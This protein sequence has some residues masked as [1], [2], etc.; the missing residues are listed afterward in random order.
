[1]ATKRRIK[2]RREA[3]TY[4][5]RKKPPPFCLKEIVR[6]IRRNKKFAKFIAEQLCKAHKGDKEAAACVD[7]Y[8]K[9]TNS[10]L[11]ALC[12]PKSLRPALFDKC[13]DH[14]TRYLLIDVA[15]HGVGETRKC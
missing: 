4:A 2:T 11:N 8:Y 6:K 7:S 3:K 5:S 13:T 14:P 9:P 12:I 1:M 10:E 15:A